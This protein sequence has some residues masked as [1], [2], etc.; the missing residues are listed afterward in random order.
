MMT[1]IE[2]EV[3]KIK[4]CPWCGMAPKIKIEEIK[5]TPKRS[6]FKATFSCGGEKKC[7]RIRYYAKT[8]KSAI[9]NG[10]EFWND[11]VSLEEKKKAGER[12]YGQFQYGVS[13]SK[14]YGKK[15]IE[16]A[17]KEAKEDG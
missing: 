14:F 10:T 9:E 15:L 4:A 6:G 1:V 13:G 7:K 17:D 5:I 8:E 2:K 16:I 3:P 12:T 11:L